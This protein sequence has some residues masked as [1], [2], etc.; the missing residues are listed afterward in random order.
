[1]N[2]NFFLLDYFTDE[3][4]KK[5]NTINR[6]VLTAESSRERRKTRVSKYLQWVSQVKYELS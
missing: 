4:I 5:L 3:D 2:M 1:M 6:E